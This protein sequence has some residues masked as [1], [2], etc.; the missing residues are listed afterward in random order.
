MKTMKLNRLILPVLLLAAV[1]LLSACNGNKLEKSFTLSQTAVT[2]MEGETA[3]LTLVSETFEEG[4][5][6]VEWESSDSVVVSVSSQGGI[7]ALSKGSAKITATV[8]VGDASAT[9]SAT[10]TVTASTAPLTGLSFGST[11]YNLGQGQTL[12]LNS[13]VEYT[14][15]YAANKSLTWTSSN[16]SIATVNN[17]VVVP[18]SQ[19]I[20][21]ITAKSSDGT[22]SA[23]CT[24]RVSE[25]SVDATGVSLEKTEYTLSVGSSLVINPTVVPTNAT[26]YTF[27]WEV[28]DPSIATVS[29]GKVVGVS[30]GE[31]TLQVSLS[32]NSKLKAECKITVRKA[33]A[34][35][36]EA[37]NV[38]LRPGYITVSAEEEGP[39]FFHW[40][41]T[42]I[43]STQTP[44]WTTNR[45][46]VLSID[47]ES[48]KFYVIGASSNKTIS[49]IVTCTIGKAS[50]TGVVNVEPRKPELQIST[51][52]D[53]ILYDK[54]PRNTLELVAAMTGTNALANV[55]WKSSDTTV[56]TVNEFGIVTAKKAGSVTITATDV[57]DP[58]V[59]ATY[60]ITVE[61]ANFFTIAVGETVSLDLDPELY[62][63]DITWQT[64]RH[65]NYDAQ[66]NTITGVEESPHDIPGKLMGFSASDGQSYTVIV[67]VVP[68]EN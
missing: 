14:P 63:D 23:A 28:E 62:P 31:T 33:S 55:T 24:I 36:I 40:D 18:M 8:T 66:N 64:S 44:T 65:L 15:S 43:N 29:G 50:A 37:T 17:G 19:G 57:E 7:T 53:G 52:G 47:E 21:T 25:M 60:T 27:L 51:D 1:L 42:P 30:E 68:A 11:I 10:V 67:Y 58:T 46:D 56:A 59:K 2:L 38:Q 32:S 45:P 54:A 9:F 16:P 13:E 26:G 49:V 20:T 4:D 41:V 61:K 39:F 34:V 12:N 48:G 3:T 22:V 6:D 5:Y 35:D